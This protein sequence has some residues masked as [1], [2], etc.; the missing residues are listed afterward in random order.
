MHRKRRLLIRVLAVLM[1]RGYLAADSIT[2]SDL[3]D[4]DTDTI[5]IQ[6]APAGGAVDGLPGATTGWGFAVG[7]TSTNG[8]WVS[9]TARR[10]VPLISHSARQAA[11]GRKVLMVCRK[12]LALTRLQPAPR[13]EHRTQ[14]RLHSISRFTTAIRSIRIPN[15]LEMDLMR[16]T[17]LQR[18][19][20]LP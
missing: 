2:L 10:V 8:D 15:K 5:S 14:V 17:A 6:L 9:F 1:T 12:A 4:G 19:F 18:T 20:R 13:P 16:I 3:P 7:W 11:R